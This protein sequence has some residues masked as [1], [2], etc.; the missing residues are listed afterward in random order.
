MVRVWV[1]GVL[2]AA[3]LT[4]TQS[5]SIAQT[6]QCSQSDPDRLTNF[7]IRIYVTSPILRNGGSVQDEAVGGAEVKLSGQGIEV[8]GLTD[9]SGSCIFDNL[10]PGEYSITAKRAH[11]QL[12]AQVHRF[13]K[14]VLPQ[15]NFAVARLSL[16]EEPECPY[17]VGEPTVKCLDSAIKQFVGDDAVD[18]GKGYITLRSA[19]KPITKCVHK[20]LAIRCRTSPA[21]STVGTFFRFALCLTNRIG[22]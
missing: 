4:L 7:N 20:S 12:I 17:R 1:K 21:L 8:V 13:F 19:V 3:L 11:G 10:D 6:S 18:C 15:F 2:F 5:G 22:L 14:P 16:R 9:A